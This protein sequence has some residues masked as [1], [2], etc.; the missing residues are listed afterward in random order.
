MGERTRRVATFP[1]RS[2]GGW[3]GDHYA[4]H[5]SHKGYT[6]GLPFVYPIFLPD[7]LREAE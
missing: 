6:L 1:Q 5:A 7:L 2:D 4:Q 3:D